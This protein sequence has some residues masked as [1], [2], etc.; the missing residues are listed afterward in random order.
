MPETH[1]ATTSSTDGSVF[2]I[3]VACLLVVFFTPFI[4]LLFYSVPA[5]DDFC[6]ATLAFD[7]IP[8][9]SL[10]ALTWLYYTKWSPRW[11][12]V[13]FLGGSMS[14]GDLMGTYG[15]L[16]L[17]VLI[18]TVASLWYFFWAV[19]RLTKSSSFLIAAI[20]CAAWVSSI[21]NVDEQVYW[22]TNVIVY[23]LPLCTM[24]VLLGLL[25]RFGGT[26]LAYA[27]LVLLSVAVPAQHEIA[28]AFVVA[29]A[30][31]GGTLLRMRK[32]EAGPWF[33]CF[34]VSA[35]SLAAVL[36]SP[37]NA[38]RAA[39]EHRH[40]WDV[41]HSVR[42]F[43]H[44][45]Y[46]GLNWLSTPAI[47]LGAGCAVVLAQS[48][49]TNPAPEDALPQRWLA[50]GGVAGLLIVLCLS[51]LVEIA[52]SIW[53]PPRVVALFQ[54]IFWLLFFCV[55]LSGIPEVYQ[56]RLGAPTKAGI[57]ALLA[58]ALLG[59]SNF[60]AATEDLR[61]PARSWHNFALARLRHRGGSQSFEAPAGFPKLAKPQMLI[62]D[63]GCWVNRCLANYLHADTVVV[64]NSKDFCP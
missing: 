59:S 2:R 22:L 27:A 39:A 24:L 4:A 10:L 48:S 64:T 28:G 37:G 58:V 13:L 61:G 55:I 1:A 16:L 34:L 15:W 38:A 43:A 5:A 49:R 7:T 51:S 45:F 18:S 57:A 20:F 53:L 41:G 36:L 23:N 17:L 62:S 25:C 19:F 31:A 47:L 56:T 63:P 26:V 29:V 3:A 11:L 32:R 46:T 9:P 52:T 40:L 50:I 14:H 8:Q 54:F 42:W 35:I 30:L 60:R 6:N 21:T 33:L 12:T 44:S